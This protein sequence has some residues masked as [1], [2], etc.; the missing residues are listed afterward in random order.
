[1]KH[2]AH[3]L[4]QANLKTDTAVMIMTATRTMVRPSGVPK[5]PGNYWQSLYIILLG[6][7]FSAPIFNICI[8]LPIT[9]MNM[10][11]CGRPCTWLSMKPHP[12]RMP[13]NV[14]IL[15]FSQAKWNWWWPTVLEIVKIAQYIQC[16][17]KCVR[18]LYHFW[19]QNCS[20]Q[21][22]YLECNYT[23]LCRNQQ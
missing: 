13:A 11:C 23:I 20:R 19:D 17:S 1:M 22:F 12:F 4:K 2:V 15:L 7:H 16:R 18:C 3:M 14:Y 6:T 21:C 8:V 10:R 9:I 5:L